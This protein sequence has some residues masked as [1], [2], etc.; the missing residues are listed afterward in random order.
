MKSDTVLCT[1][2]F[3]IE[4]NSEREKEKSHIN[5]D[6]RHGDGRRKSYKWR[7]KS[8]YQI[9][10][11]IF[12]FNINVSPFTRLLTFIMRV[13]MFMLLIRFVPFELFPSDFANENVKYFYSLIRLFIPTARLTFF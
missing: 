11:I 8:S 3:N 13:V 7:D 2:M 4:T 12:I 10:N 6:I 9:F 5:M 1:A